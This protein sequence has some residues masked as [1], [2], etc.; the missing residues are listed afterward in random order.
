MSQAQGS[1]N[2]DAL[3]GSMVQ[4]MQAGQNMAQ[5]FLSFLGK[6]AG[7]KAVPEPKVDTVALNSLQKNFLN[8]QMQLWQAIMGRGRGQEPG[9]AFAVAPEPGDR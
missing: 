4:F 7:E 8:E 9:N 3:Y 5:H 6:A 2:N 1:N